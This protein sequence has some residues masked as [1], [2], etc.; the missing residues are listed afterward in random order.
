VVQYWERG[1]GGKKGGG[2]GGGGGGRVKGVLQRKVSAKIG[3]DRGGG[4]SV[5]GGRGG[6][7][8]SGGA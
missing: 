6:K 4:G 1:G 7:V 8:L 3:Q 2:G 5:V